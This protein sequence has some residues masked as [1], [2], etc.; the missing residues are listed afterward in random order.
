MTLN[1]RETSDVKNKVIEVIRVY[2][3]IVHAR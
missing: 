1:K 3:T 2:D